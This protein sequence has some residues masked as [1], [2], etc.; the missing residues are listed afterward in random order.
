ML[1]GNLVGNIGGEPEMRYTSSGE[2][3]L[4]FNVASNYRKRN[5]EGEWVDRVEWVR[6]IVFGKRAEALQDIIKKGQK[7]YVYGR[8]ECDPWVTKED[9]VRAGVQM[10][11]Q[12]LEIVSPR[13]SNGSSGG[14]KGWGNDMTGSPSKSRATATAGAATGGRLEDLD[15]DMLPF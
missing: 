9:E 8:M 4:R 14:D 11:S 13:D 15:D 12:E 2:A 6:V 10:I 7:V 5:A 3:V 1:T